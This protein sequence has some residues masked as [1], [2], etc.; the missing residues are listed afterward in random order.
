MVDPEDST[1]SSVNRGIWIV[2]IAVVLMVAVNA[3]PNPPALIRNGEAIALTAH[4]K[5]CLGILLFAVTLWVTEALP[6]AVTSL[7]VL[8]LIPVFGIADYPSVVAAGFGNP[9]ITFFIGVSM[10]SAGFSHS[11][12]GK[13]LVLHVLRI[14]GTKTDRVLL[15]FL[16]AGAALS[17]WIT[18]MAVAAMMMP[19]GVG[20][21]RD[22]GLSPL[23]SNFGRGLMISCAYGPLIGGVG[24]PAGTGVN[25]I[26]LSYLNEL[27]GLEISFIRW[28]TIG[29]PAVLLM[30]PLGWWVLLKV[31]PPE[32]DRLP[33]ADEDIRNQ[34]KVLGPPTTVERKTLMVFAVTISLWLGTPLFSLL[35]NGVVN[36]S[37]QAVGLFGGVALF[38]PG[39]NALTWKQAQRDVDWGGV[40]LI[41]SGLSLGLMIFETGAA[42]WL[43]QLL[44]GRLGFV[45]LLVQ[46]FVVVLVVA[47]LH[48][49]FSSNTVTGSIIMPIVIA[50]AQDLGL[51]VWSV[52]APAAFTS[53]L[54]FIL[55]TESPTN[56][57]P[58]SAGYFSIR[59]MAKSGVW[60]TLVAA[61][62]VTLSVVVVGAILQAPGEG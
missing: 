52:A 34:L 50:L 40:V 48:L 22:A 26:A 6:F 39:I 43:A 36:P 54:A 16:V 17:M 18:D 5:A 3:L 23:K 35:T 31:F 60:M 11:G 58:Y 20:V 8:L 61:V 27:A 12:L 37:L 15:G 9:I 41:V 24:T 62:C 45:P 49:L 42:R 28:M 33:V 47:A 55:V 10:L 4:G 56:I 2:G 19:L 57:V 1:H 29:V 7:F 13:R 30:L 53:S 32:I 44:L 59:D 25:P 14:V 51:N 38:L 46:P 21:L